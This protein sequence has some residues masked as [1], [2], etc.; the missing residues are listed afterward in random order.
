MKILGEEEKKSEVE[1]NERE[2]NKAEASKR[3]GWYLVGRP[4][5]DTSYLWQEEVGRF[6]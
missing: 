2:L 1:E 4:R 3:L 5:V 6:T